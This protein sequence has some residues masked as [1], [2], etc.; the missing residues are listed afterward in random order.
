MGICLDELRQLVIRPTLK[1]LRNWSPG[2]ENLLL[3]TAAQESQ[4]GFH[5]KQGRR[6]GL[7]IYQIQP[8]THRE[9]W[10]EYLIDHSALASK[11]RGLASQRDFLDHPHSELATNLRYATAIAWLIYRAAHVYKVD[12]GDIAAM[13]RLWH[14]HFHHGPAA[15][16]RDFECSYA[17]LISAADPTD[18]APRY[19]GEAHQPRHRGPRSAPGAR[20][21]GQPSR[22]PLA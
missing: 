8:H 6:H 20:L 14:Q 1:H 16:A 7:G 21:S 19:S 11:V 13:A 2:M 22:Q 18:C 5:L 3:G 9:I 15:S 17:R 10:D 4:L 12:E